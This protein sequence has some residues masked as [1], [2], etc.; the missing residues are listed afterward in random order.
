[1]GEIRP[2]RPH[3]LLCSDSNDERLK[4]RLD[5]DRQIGWFAPGNY[6]EPADAG[7]SVLES[8]IRRHRDR[9]ATIVLALMP[10]RSP[11]REATPAEA[12]GRIRS[13]NAGPFRDR[14][15]PILDLRDAVPDADFHDLDHLAPPGSAIASRRLA[16][17]LKSLL[18]PARGR[19]C[20]PPR[21]GR[22]LQ[23][24]SR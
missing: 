19:S 14:P 11:Q 5:Y 8:L 9:G 12:L 20:E 2:D 3:R 18:P 4:S 23:G 17:G 13:L 15:V 10:E 16:E 22:R 24:R 6:G 21:S 7:M 1:M